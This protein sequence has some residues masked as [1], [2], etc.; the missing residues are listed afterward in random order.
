MAILLAALT[1]C[2]ATNAGEI[3]WQPNLEVARQAAA[4][5]NRLVLVH[6]WAPWCQPCVRMESQVYQVPGV[7]PQIEARF[8]PVKLNADENVGLAREFGVRSIP[9]DVILSP[10]GE[11]IARLACQPR[12][13]QY[14]AQL[15]QVAGAQVESNTGAAA[16]AQ[17]P[18]HMGGQPVAQNSPTMPIATGYG[19]VAAESAGLAGQASPAQAGMNGNNPY[20]GI[21]SQPTGSA[22]PSPYGA[23]QS[24]VNIQASSQSTVPEFGL[25]GYCPIELLEG[26][27]WVKGDPRWGAVHMGVTYL[28]AG[29]SQQQ[30]FLAN[31]D[32]YSPVFAGNDPVYFVDNN[33]AVAGKREFGVYFHD[34]IYLFANPQARERFAQDPSRYSYETL[35]ARRLGTG[36]V[37]R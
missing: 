14:L 5:S 29:Q 22:A 12:P 3:G 19:H 7:A 33:Q 2:V 13:E 10:S 18:W 35:E 9:T 24:P 30:R 28:F 27:R 32:V 17:R 16:D 11:V 20:A 1:T 21:A 23:A 8:V 26:K 37:R 31:P 15:E 36:N 6:F 4:E 34:R 25:D